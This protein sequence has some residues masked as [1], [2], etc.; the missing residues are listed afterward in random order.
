M[1]SKLLQPIL[2]AI[3]P[4][5]IE[6]V[7]NS[8]QKELRII[9]TLEP[10]MNQHRLVIDYSVIKEDVHKVMTDPNKYLQYS[11]VYQLTHI[12]KDRNSL[13]HDDIL[14]AL[15]LGVAYWNERNILKQDTSIALER[16]KKKQID[17]EL[18]R[19]GDI[20]KKMNKQPTNIKHSLSKFRGF[21]I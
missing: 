8:K 5:T 10:L 20:F 3:Y 15:A 13:L 4:C 16:Y 19:R 21:S 14:D 18:K 17:D 1:F 12:S 2:N 11:L 6:E 7:R 9:D